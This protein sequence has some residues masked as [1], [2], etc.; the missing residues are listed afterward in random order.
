MLLLLTLALLAGLTCSAQN[1]QGKNDAKYFYVKGEDVGD[2]KGIR[3]FLSL[4]NFIKGIQLRF[5][6][7]W[8]DV[9]GSRSLK[10]KEF[11]LE[12][13]EHVT[14]VIIGGTISLL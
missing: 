2:L 8:S 3:I 11:L 1:V 5:G 12:D 6:N 4:L 14:Q 7:D 13:G 9:Y 10:Y